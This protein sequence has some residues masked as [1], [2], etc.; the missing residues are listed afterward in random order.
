MTFTQA[1]V[2]PGL[3]WHVPVKLFGHMAWFALVPVLLAL[4]DL[5]WQKALRVMSLAAWIYFTLTLYWL[6]IA[7]SVYGGLPWVASI[8]VILA[9]AGL[10]T[11]FM[12][13]AP[14]VGFYIAR[15]FPKLPWWL[16]VPTAWVAHEWARTHS[17]TGYPWANLADSQ[18]LCNLFIVQMADVFGENGV[19]WI[20]L[21]S[22][23]TLVCL[24]RRQNGRAPLALTAVL[25]VA[26]LLYGVL[27]GPQWTMPTT[28][29]SLRLAALQANIP[30]DEKWDA[31]FVEK[32]LR[33]YGALAQKASQQ[34]VN[35]AVWPEA[36]FPMF[37]D[38]ETK[39]F[40]RPHHEPMYELIGLP[41]A[42]REA[43]G[44]V[45]PYN[46]IFLVGPKGEV[47]DAYDKIH[48]V[49]FGEYVPLKKFLFFV[50][51]V[52]PAIGDFKPGQARRPLRLPSA[53]VNLGLI[54]CYEDIFPAQARAMTKLGADVLINST[55]DAWYEYSSAA[56]Q[57]LSI[58][59]YRAVEN[60]RPLLRATNTGISAW[61]S[62]RGEI[63]STLPWFE[64]GILSADLP[65][66]HRPMSLFTRWGE[67]FSGGC[68]V[69]TLF[70]FGA[71]V[72]KRRQIS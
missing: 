4:H 48:L 70:V 37:L 43:N 50:D 14:V 45:T 13:P 28:G 67:W 65:L 3:R 41:T 58:A 19:T 26:A 55:N 63:L 54:V 30:Q 60:R 12:A 29:T 21:L 35:L 5:P 39:E 40:P 20:L 2:I 10:F 32:I 11:C 24:W 56:W 52:V 6:T 62:P 51:R 49:P 42:Q 8:L 22:N 71:A 64:S 9:L 46:S 18:T 27:I 59:I 23:C 15:R 66:G 69:L 16:C 61:V 1:T 7:M 57:H 44:A 17:L 34:G 38:H 72:V 33:D 25:V 36:A 47:L 53:D 31:A 68:T